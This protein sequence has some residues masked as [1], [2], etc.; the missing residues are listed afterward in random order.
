M[1]LNTILDQ[2]DMGS[3]ALPK[4][5][6]GYVWRRRQVR[7]LMRSLYLGYPVG[8]LLMWETQTEKA[9]AKGA[10]QLASGTVRLLLDGQQRVT[11]LYGII[12][13]K[14][15]TFFD[16]DEK[17]FLNLYFNLDDEEFEFYG[18]VKMRDDPRWISVTE[19]MQPEKGI[20]IFFPQIRKIPAVIENDRLFDMYVGRLYDITNIKER[21]LHIEEVSG[22]DKTMD[23]IVDIFNEVNSAGT[24]LSKGDLALA[25]ICASWPEAR[26]EMQARLRKWENVGYHFSKRPLDWLLRCITAML[27]S[28][29]DF[30]ALFSKDE[31]GNE[32]FSVPAFQDGLR[33]AEKHIDYLLELIASRLGLDHTRVLGSPFSFPLLA[34]YI[35]QRGKPAD[36]REQDKLLYWYAHTMLWGH[37]SASM[38]TRLRRDLVAIDDNEDALEA[39]IANLY[40]SRGDLTLHPRDFEGATVGNRFYPMLYM[41]TRVCHSRDFESGIELKHNLLGSLSRL[42]L[43]HIF[44][45]ARLREYGYHWSEVNALANFTFLTKATNLKISAKLA[46]EYFAVYEDKHPGVLASHWIPMDRELWKIEN[47]RDFLAER[48]KLLAQA[49]NDFLSHLRDGVMPETT[50]AESA[51]AREIVSIPGQIADEA[52]EALLRDAMNW[53][54]QQGL[55]TGELGFEL[56]EDE[57]GDVLAMLD[58]AWPDGVQVGRTDPAA[59]LIDE[60]EETLSIAQRAG[61]R[62]FTNLEQLQHY[63][64][65]EILDRPA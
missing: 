18:P 11:S 17:A 64:E 56:V 57:S 9:E 3:V 29:S 23:D 20:R 51:L 14:P 32:R 33:R 52:E 41:M 7:K 16:G 19:L 10:A 28:Q 15:P 25:K 27:T 62:C 37:Y 53:M 58:L 54:E 42:E 34:R 47:Y 35:D 2:I 6:R 48:R 59:L 22:A 21:E 30:A 8:S 44:P 26:E 46:E 4:F 31:D 38:E 45:K 12:R 61:Y 1:K 49:A 60:G 65:K 13:G 40:Q 55:P 43:H 24:T 39:L 50:A 5:Q 36:Y 63:V